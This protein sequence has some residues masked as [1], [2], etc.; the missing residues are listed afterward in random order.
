M[1][2]SIYKRWI[3]TPKALYYLNEQKAFVS[4]SNVD[5]FTVINVDQN[6]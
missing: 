4:K 1:Q 5:I 6:Y 2:H 3:I